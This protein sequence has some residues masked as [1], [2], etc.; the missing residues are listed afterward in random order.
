MIAVAVPYQD[1]G[2]RWRAVAWS[3]GAGAAYDLLFALAILFFTRPAAALLGLD[4]PDDPV[5]L[6]LN[7]I[8]LILLAGLYL[9]PAI[10]PARYQ[11]VVVVGSIGRLLGFVYLGL[12]WRSGGGQAFGGL[13]L[14]DL[15]FA[16][17]HVILLVR[18]RAQV[19]GK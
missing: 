1:G 5:Y 6:R 18:A 2:D 9:L 17:I 7:G 11:G 19:A 4:L 3:M 16:V 13:A 10:S 14:A 15:A 12:V 8:F